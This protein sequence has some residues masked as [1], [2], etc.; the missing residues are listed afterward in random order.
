MD[1]GNKKRRVANRKG[2]LFTLKCR[3]FKNYLCAE[4]TKDLRKIIAQHN[5]GSGAWQDTADGY[6]RKVTDKLRELAAI[7]VSD[8]GP[9]LDEVDTR[10]SEIIQ[11]AA[12]LQHSEGRRGS[13]EDA[14]AF[15]VWTD[16]APLLG[17]VQGYVL[18][19][20]KRAQ[21]DEARVAVAGQA[22]KKEEEMPLG[23]EKYAFRK[24]GEIWRIRY[25]GKDL[26]LKDYKGLRYIQELLRNP[27]KEI[28]VLDLVSLT[29]PATGITQGIGGNYQGDNEDEGDHAMG[30]KSRAKGFEEL[31]RRRKEL[32]QAKALHDSDPSKRLQV[33][34]AQYEVRRLLDEL[35]LSGDP[36]PKER[37]AVAACI[38]RAMKKIKKEHKPLWR[39][40]KNTV[41][42][43]TYCAYSPED[44][45]P[46]WV[47]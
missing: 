26:D 38:D 46:D 36:Y 34:E 19:E 33:A 14:L 3:E 39:Y 23:E 45:P 31:R 25:G 9:K 18:E 43:G 13:W 4:W 6:V 40:L 11:W 1:R 42:L 37:K 15:K 24:V 20:V 47:L 8:Y 22:P 41:A 35:G 27:N 28:S 21:K 30:A 17:N 10:T 32:K 2:E 12:F 29:S 16:V 44:P 5:A 7:A